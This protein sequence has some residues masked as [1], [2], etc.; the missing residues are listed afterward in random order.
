MFK[1]VLLVVTGL[2]AVSGGHRESTNVDNIEPRTIPTDVRKDF[3]RRQNE[4]ERSLADFKPANPNVIV[5][6]VD[7]MLKGT[8]GDEA[9]ELFR[10]LY[11]N[12]WG[13]VR[14]I[15]SSDLIMVSHIQIRRLTRSN[16]GSTPGCRY[17][18]IA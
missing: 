17:P 2:I 6:D 11:P 5:R 15:L 7:K 18:R 12:A 3:E 4:P 8:R 14:A 9:L 13:Y 10:K 16:A 1:H